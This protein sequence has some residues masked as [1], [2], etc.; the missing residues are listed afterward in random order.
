[1]PRGARSS[2]DGHENDG[3]SPVAVHAGT[4]GE[5]LPVSDTADGRLALGSD[6]PFVDSFDPLQNVR[7]V[8]TIGLAPDTGG[9]PP[10]SPALPLARVLQA[11]TSGSAWASFDEHRKGTLARGMLADLVILSADIFAVPLGDLRDVVVTT[12]IFNGR[13]VYT[14]PAP[15]PTE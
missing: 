8:L 10:G 12:T 13:V 3:V 2:A 15:S 6:W 7:A 14:R 9:F 5:I 4:P 1:V 11:Y